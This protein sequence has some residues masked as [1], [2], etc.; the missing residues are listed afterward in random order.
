MYIVLS[1]SYQMKY[2]SG[3]ELRPI[4]SFVG[5]KCNWHSLISKFLQTHC[6]AY[7]LETRPSGGSQ[8]RTFPGFCD[9]STTGCPSIIF[10]SPVAAQRAIGIYVLPPT[11]VVA[12]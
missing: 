5:A 4:S 3:S 12:L 6:S 11:I 10:S 8:E 1:S 9:C 7:I 2:L